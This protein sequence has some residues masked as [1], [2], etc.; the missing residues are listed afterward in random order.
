MDLAADTCGL[1]IVI[2][3]YNEADSLRELHREVAAGCGATGLDYEVIFV[4]DGSTDD[5]RAV[6]NALA[7]ADPR[8][9]VVEFRRNF[10]KSPALA[11]GFETV[12]GEIV[13]TLDADLQ[14]D[15]AFIPQF[16]KAIEDGADLV[17]GWKKVRHDPLGKTLPSRVF[18]AVVRGISG[19]PLRDFNCGFKAYRAECI[20]ELN[21]YGGLHRFMPVLAS[22]RGFRIGELVVEHRPRQHG[23]SKFG[24]SRFFDGV[25]DLMTVLLLTRFRLRPLHFFGIPGAL[26]ST[27]GVLL[28]SYLSVLWLTGVGIGRRPLLTLGVLMTIM[29]GQFLGIGLLAELLVRTTIQPREVF[30]VRRR[31]RP[32]PDAT[33]PPALAAPPAAVV[34]SPE[35][36]TVR[37]A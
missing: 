2:P 14:D 13:I 26:L 9:G 28:L 30:S 25:L 7:D 27:V 17:S 20:R 24:S 16:V 29:G 32:T 6:I 15:P 23:S 36:S 37:G 5:S 11:A 21:V 33:R 34:D 10:G 18:N 22:A 8:V 19:V 12:R 4:D 1:S 31:R 35:S 3:V